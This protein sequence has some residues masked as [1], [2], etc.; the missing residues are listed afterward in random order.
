MYKWKLRAQHR[1]CFAFTLRSYRKYSVYSDTMIY[2]EK[3]FKRLRNGKH[4]PNDRKIFLFSNL[5]LFSVS[6]I[7]RYCTLRSPDTLACLSCHIKKGRSKKKWIVSGKVTC[8][9]G[10]KVLLEGSPHFPLGN[11]KGLCGQFP[12]WCWSENSRLTG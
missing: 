10:T 9:L 12:H 8:F 2:C 7:S 5:I 4:P 11:R 3:N 1:I 6:F